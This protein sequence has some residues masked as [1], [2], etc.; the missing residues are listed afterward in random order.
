MYTCIGLTPFFF[1]YLFRYFFS[2][3]SYCGTIVISVNTISEKKWLF[4]FVNIIVFDRQK[5]YRTT[6]AKFID[7]ILFP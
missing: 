4:D 7:N 1:F 2:R 3:Q 5:A 6:N